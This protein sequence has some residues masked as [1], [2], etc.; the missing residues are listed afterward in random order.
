MAARKAMQSTPN[1]PAHVRLSVFSLRQPNTTWDLSPAAQPSSQLGRR[2]E[3][4]TAVY[5]EA[6]T[7]NDDPTRQ[8][9]AGKSCLI[10]FGP[11]P[12]HNPVTNY[13]AREKCGYLFYGAP[14]SS[15][16]DPPPEH[17][18]NTTRGRSGTS[19][20]GKS[21]GGGGAQDPGS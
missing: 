15:P 11:H 6:T 17:Y 10:L 18:Y 21:R 13:E 9:L 5:G 8:G 2:N 20:P 3:D 7:A 12:S 19:A 16:E 4:F 1:Y 14:K